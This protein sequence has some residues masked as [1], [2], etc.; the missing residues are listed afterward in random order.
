METNDSRGKEIRIQTVLL[1]SIFMLSI[2][3]FFTCI[4]YFSEAIESKQTL[5]KL[6]EEH[7]GIKNESIQWRRQVDKELSNIKALIIKDLK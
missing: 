3:S 4:F 5:G 2:F 7:T 6:S 1:F